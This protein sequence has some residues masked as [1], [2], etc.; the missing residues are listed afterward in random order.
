LSVSFCVID[1]VAHDSDRLFSY[2]CHLL[3]LFISLVSVWVRPLYHSITL[4]LFRN[5]F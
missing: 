4:N 2:H 5:C 3:G 1:G